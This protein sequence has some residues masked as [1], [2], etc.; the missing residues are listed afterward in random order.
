[1]TTD[2][3]NKEFLTKVKAIAKGPDREFFA[4]VVESKP[5]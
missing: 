1:M 3:K 5:C 4:R 2:S